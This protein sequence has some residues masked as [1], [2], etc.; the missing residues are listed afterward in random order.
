MRWLVL[1]RFVLPGNCYEMSF[2]NASV[3][4]CVLFCEVVLSELVIDLNRVQTEG[5]RIRKEEN[6]KRLKGG[7]LFWR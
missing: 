7:K 6:E 5:E 2:Y 1:D 4:L 3:C